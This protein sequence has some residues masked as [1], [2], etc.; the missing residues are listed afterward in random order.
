LR[1]ISTVS[2]PALLII[3]AD[4]LQNSR[5]LVRRLKLQ[6]SK[7]WGRADRESKL[8]FKQYLLSKMVDRLGQ[9]EHE[10]NQA[11]VMGTHLLLAE[12]AETVQMLMST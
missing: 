1:Q 9:L 7:G 10:P 3:A 5:V 2:L 4:K 8:W 11:M 12:Y 6:G